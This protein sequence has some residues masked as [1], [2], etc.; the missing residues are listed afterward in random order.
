M[1][2]G[3]F[4]RKD[5]RQQSLCKKL[6]SKVGPNPSLNQAVDIFF[7]V[8]SKADHNDDEMLLYEVGLYPDC[9][10]CLVRQIPNDDEEYCQLHLELHFEVTETNKSLSECKWHEKGDDDL[11][12]YILNSEA[13]CVLKEMKATRINIF[14][15]ET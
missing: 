15:D 3:L 8:I 4:K 13:Y 7:E 2:M 5:D 10:F 11:K 6:I 14:T 1:P 12:E 9:S